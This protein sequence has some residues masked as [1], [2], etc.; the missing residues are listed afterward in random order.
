MSYGSP[1]RVHEATASVVAMLPSVH[2]ERIREVLGRFWAASASARTPV[3]P[4]DRHEI[5]RRVT[6]A[7]L[8][9][10][11]V[12]TAI[13]RPHAVEIVARSGGNADWYL[14]V[15]TGFGDA[16]GV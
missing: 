2:P 15:R 4:P 9:D 14:H 11:V 5:T 6:D 1:V 12:L 16:D 3:S 10:D 13:R 8:A 7:A